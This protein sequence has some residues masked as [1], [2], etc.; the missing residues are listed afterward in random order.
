MSS[1]PFTGFPGFLGS[2]LLPRVLGRSKDAVAV[3][4]VQSKFADVA[5]ARAEA[6]ERK[7]PS[8]RGRLT[9][10]EGDITTPRLGLRD[11]VPARDVIEIFHLAAV[12]DL[13]VARELAHRVNVGGTR[14]VLEFAERCPR[15]ARFQ[16]V[17]TC[18]VS[19]RYAAT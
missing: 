15:L 7:H 2:Q 14:H 4:L 19:G 9:L 1:I 6:L 17:S 18:Y 5:R 8:L 3:C 11:Q 10:I 16:Y 13:S 12:Y